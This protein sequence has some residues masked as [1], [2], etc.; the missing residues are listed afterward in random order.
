MR[1]APL[2]TSFRGIPAVAVI[3]SLVAPRRML[4]RHEANQSRGSTTSTQQAPY[5]DYTE[6]SRAALLL[7]GPW[8]LLKPLLK[9][10]LTLK[11]TPN[12]TV[13]VEPAVAVD[14]TV[15]LQRIGGELKIF[16]LAQLNQ[17]LD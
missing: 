7:T 10:Q 1:F 3:A 15:A 17:A 6:D 16:A 9:L 4:L 14:E 13:L 2:S 12:P 11:Q 8:A 5:S